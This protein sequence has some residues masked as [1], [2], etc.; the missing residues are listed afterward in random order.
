MTAIQST[1][2]D[3]TKSAASS[4][5]KKSNWYHLGTGGI[6]KIWKVYKQ[7]KTFL[8]EILTALFI[9]ALAV[10]YWPAALVAICILPMILM[11]ER[12]KMA[13]LLE[14]NRALKDQNEQINK[15]NISL[16]SVEASQRVAIG[17]LKTN[18]KVVKEERD[19]AK[20]LWEKETPPLILERDQLLQKKGELLKKIDQA[21][22]EKS[23]AIQ[24]R[25]LARE[26]MIEEEGKQEHTR[27]GK[28]RLE[29]ECKSLKEE[30][31]AARLEVKAA[32]SERDFALI[33][34]QTQLITERDLAIFKNSMLEEQIKELKSQKEGEIQALL[35][36]NEEALLEL[37]GK[38][39]PQLSI[40]PI[41]NYLSAFQQDCQKLAESPSEKT[42]EDINAL[43]L[44]FETM[45]ETHLASIQTAIDQSEDDFRFRIHMMGLQ[46]M[47]KDQ[48]SL[49][50]KLGQMIGDKL[51]YLKALSMTSYSL[52]SGNCS[53]QAYKNHL[54]V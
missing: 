53:I 33:H 28:E 39:L 32:L 54:F 27:L 41:H 19:R 51:K 34:G 48:S 3:V 5:E 13:P 25:D 6:T 21:D 23:D 18:M 37:K 46:H 50:M 47:F 14:E 7:K 31:A 12:S 42:A 45:K 1:L 44:E 16:S 52:E 36:K 10:I 30:L 11:I 15:N 22:V 40:E 35:Q 24:E 20:E 38:I 9:A 26:K 49:L 8:T 43:L 2:F 4:L 17:H 29:M